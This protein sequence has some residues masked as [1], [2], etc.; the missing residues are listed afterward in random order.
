VPFTSLI[1]HC[2]C[3][4]TDNCS[5]PPSA[6]YHHNHCT[7]PS[8]PKSL[9]LVCVHR[10]PMKW[11]NR[12]MHQTTAHKI[13]PAGRCGERHDWI[14]IESSS[15]NKATNSGGGALG[16]H[17]CIAYASPLFHSIPFHLS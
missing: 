2:M 4:L 12:S 6:Y 9:R 16:M 15:S 17:C 8:V 7:A 10:R 14:W 3:R 13:P 11:C 5:L 1:A